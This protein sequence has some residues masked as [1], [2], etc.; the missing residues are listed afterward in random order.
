MIRNF[1][2]MTLMGIKPKTLIHVGAHLGQDNHQYELLGVQ[3]IFWC[4][5]DPVCT[6]FIRAKYPRSK[7]VEGVF[8]SEAGVIRDFWIMQDRAQNSLF[9]PKMEVGK[10]DSIKVSTTTLDSEFANI[11]FELPLMMVLD[12]QGSELEVLRG[13][14]QILPRVDYLVCEITE[15]SRTSN[16]STRLIDVENI[17]KPFGFKKSIKRQSHSGEY[18]D[19]LFIKAEIFQTCRIILI[20]SA[21]RFFKGVR[22]LLI[23]LQV[24]KP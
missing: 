24:D 1:R 12:V 2:L 4:E 6:S 17:L 9:N 19:Q 23:K 13:A 20:E 7:V 22:R 14:I 16:F 5:A 3:E 10:L 21:Y 11:K 18:Y 8:W 15:L